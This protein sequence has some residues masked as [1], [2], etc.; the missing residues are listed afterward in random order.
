MVKVFVEP[1]DVKVIFFD[2]V[3]IASLSFCVSTNCLKALASGF[4]SLR[5]LIVS[6]VVLIVRHQFLKSR[7]TSIDL[8]S[9]IEERLIIHK[10]KE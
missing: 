9:G 1:P 3:A 5:I 7:L 2:L 10:N 8:I 6:F 4:D